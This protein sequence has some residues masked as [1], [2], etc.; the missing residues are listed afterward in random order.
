MGNLPKNIL[1]AKRYKKKVKH[2]V[3][4]LQLITPSLS[5]VPPI[6]PLS[7][8]FTSFAAPPFN[9]RV[10]PQFSIN[11]ILVLVLVLSTF[12]GYFTRRTL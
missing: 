2:L 8:P 10:I 1:D 12:V 3:G 9:R 7:S 5:V 11:V 6:I 4:K